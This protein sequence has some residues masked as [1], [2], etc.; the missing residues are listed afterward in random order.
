MH[1]IANIYGSDDG[2]SIKVVTF[3]PGAPD[4]VMMEFEIH[5]IDKR[6]NDLLRLIE[7]M[8]VS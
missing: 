7:D 6:F 3:T 8:E 5:Y 1:K 4:V 2:Q